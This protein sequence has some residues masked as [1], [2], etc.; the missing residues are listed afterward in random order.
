MELEGGESPM[1]PSTLRYVRLEQDVW[2]LLFRLMPR[3]CKEVR[4]SRE[5]RKLIAAEVGEK[6]SFSVE[7]KHKL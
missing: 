5:R 4:E 6:K 2:A 1:K 3:A 7:I